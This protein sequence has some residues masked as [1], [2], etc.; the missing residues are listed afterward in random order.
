MREPA[1]TL[2]LCKLGRAFGESS[3]RACKKRGWNCF[4]KLNQF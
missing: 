2:G 1:K 3:K 4:I